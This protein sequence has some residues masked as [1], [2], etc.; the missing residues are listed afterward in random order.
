MQTN[1]AKIEQNEE[2]N[3]IIREILAGKTVKYDI[4]QKR[5]RL[6]I[7]SL[8]RKMIKNE[9]D[10]DDLVQESFI[11]AFN[12]LDKF[13]E[14]YSFSSWLYRIASNTC[15]DFLRKKRFSTISIDNPG[16]TEEDDASIDIKDESYEA[17][18]EVLAN[19]R[20]KALFEAI[21]ELPENYREIIEL[22][23]EQELDYKDISDRLDMPL[24]TV[25][26]HLFRARKML[27]TKLKKQR[28]L[29]YDS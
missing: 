13:Q 27:L 19:E 26:A 5:Y 7:S 29:F 11:K 17:D 10:I 24:G 15:I 22:R 1:Q 28:H 16:Y 23:H 20:K 4:L 6:L 18:L 9:D 3:R 25:K 12:A 21:A 14:G 2:D 8:I